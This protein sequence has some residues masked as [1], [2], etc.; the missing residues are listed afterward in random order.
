MNTFRLTRRGVSGSDLR[1]P[2]YELG[3]GC[4]AD[5]RL[6][7]GT[8]AKISR[9]PGPAVAAPAARPLGPRTSWDDRAQDSGGLPDFRPEPTSGMFGE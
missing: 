6:R 3:A 7:Q 4:P 9:L 1:R 5:S 8:N 2:S